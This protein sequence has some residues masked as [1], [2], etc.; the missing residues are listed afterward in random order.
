VESGGNHPSNPLTVIHRSPYEQWAFDFGADGTAASQF[1]D[2]DGDGVVKLLEFAFNLDPTEADMAVYDPS[3][4]PGSGLPRMV[5]SPG[6][7]LSPSNFS[8]PMCRA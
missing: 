1:A 5:V 8:V 6:P 2:E 4:I 7:V 3:V